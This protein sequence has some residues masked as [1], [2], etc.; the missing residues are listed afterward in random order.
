MRKN[1]VVLIMV[2][3]SLVV[4]AL[5]GCSKDSSSTYGMA[6]GPSPSPAP[7]TVSMSGMAFSP[8]TM[9]IAKGTTVT[10][11]NNDGVAHTSTSNSGVWDT[12]NIPAGGSKTTTFNNA[13]TFP[14]HCVYHSTMTGTIIVQ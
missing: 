5:F 12:G 8:A 3:A 4:A 6:P 11:L 2:I 7:N 10:W 13:G 14:F 1:R 9:T